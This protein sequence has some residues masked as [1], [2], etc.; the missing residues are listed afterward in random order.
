MVASGLHTRRHIT[1]RRD[2]GLTRRCQ[3]GGPRVPM[4]DLR[5][6]VVMLAVVMQA[7]CVRHHLVT[8]WVDSNELVDG[9]R[10]LLQVQLHSLSLP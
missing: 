3:R 10:F 1:D 8:E 7:Q 5:A 6:A 2:V 4:T 9:T